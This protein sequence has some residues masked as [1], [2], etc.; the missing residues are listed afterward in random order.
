[1]L[2]YM[3]N[4]MED[5]KDFGWV[6]ANDAHVFSILCRMEKGKVNLLMS[7]KTRLK[8]AHDQK[9]FIYLGFYVA[10]NT[11]QVIS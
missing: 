7:E 5:A 8:R 3:T 11:V 4:I 2:D 9:V 1:M 10:F 6:S